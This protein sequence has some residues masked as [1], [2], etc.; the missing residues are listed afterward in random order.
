MTRP[1][2]LMTRPT[3][4]MTRP[5]PLMTRP[6]PFMTRP[7]PLMT[8]PTRLIDRVSPGRFARMVALA[9]ATLLALTGC[10]ASAGNTQRAPSIAVVTGLYPLAQAAA[11]VGGAAVSVSDVVPAGSNPLTYRLSPAQITQVR[12]AAV[13]ILA[14]PGFQPS[15]DAAASGA[16]RVLD[17]GAALPTSDN[18]AWLDPALMVRAVSAIATALEG[19]NPRA[20]GLYRNGARGFS[21]EVTSTGIDYQSTLSVCPQ[22][23]IVTADGAFVDM[24][25][26]YGLTDQVIGPG[27]QSGPALQAAAAAA[28]SADASTAFREPF[29]AAGSI[30]ALANAAH[31]KVRVLDPLTGPPPGGWPPQANYIRLMEANL[32]ALNG[33]LHCPNTGIGA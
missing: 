2:P 23:T 9:A 16:R 3:P 15:L 28:R 14:G 20:A 30:E 5:T 24:A 6:T 19:A 13:V 11:Q 10:Q 4:F 21:A 31:L 18:Y 8:R 32:G 33:A 1:T 25:R 22:R 7:T 29:V 26:S 12:R 27:D 17:L